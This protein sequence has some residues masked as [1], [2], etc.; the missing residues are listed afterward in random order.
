MDALVAQQQLE[1][2][3]TSLAELRARET[4]RG[5]VVTLGDVLFELDR[6]ELKP[7][8]TRNLDQLAASL[9]Q[10]PKAS[11][12]VEGHTDATGGSSYNRSLSERRA[13][14]VRDYLVSRG[15]DASRIQARGVGPDY[16]VATN[17]TESGRQQN[18]RVEVIIENDVAVAGD[19]PLD[20]PQ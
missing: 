4:E 1:S 14:A 18:R 7:G 17:A 8:A 3:R 11:I 15:V 20:D 5:L 16:P 9:R 12:E 6:A 13:Q 19:E 10:N 2:M